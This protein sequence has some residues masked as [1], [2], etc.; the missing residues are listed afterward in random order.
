MKK[1]KKSVQI[2]S[3]GTYTC[4]FFCTRTHAQTYT[5]H[6][7]WD[8]TTCSVIASKLSN[9]KFRRAFVFIFEYLGCTSAQ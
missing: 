4:T 6:R 9:K 8:W 3:T 1:I 2:N 7:R 5:L